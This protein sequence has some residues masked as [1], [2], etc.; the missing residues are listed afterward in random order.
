MDTYFPV[1][2]MLQCDVI[3]SCLYVSESVGSLYCLRPLLTKKVESKA[4]VIKHVGTNMLAGLEH[5]RVCLK[6]GVEYVGE[7]MGRPVIPANQLTVLENTYKP[8]VM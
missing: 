2:V 6:P 3:Q 4:C 7:E 5:V 8:T 1:A